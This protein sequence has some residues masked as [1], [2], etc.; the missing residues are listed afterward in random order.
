MPKPLTVLALAAFVAVDVALVAGVYS[1]VNQDPPTTSA[2]SEATEQPRTSDQIAFDFDPTDAGV[3]DVANDGTFVFA[4]RGDCE[5]KG[6]KL[7]VSEEY[8]ADPEPSKVGLTSIQA[9][10]ASTDGRLTVAGSDQDCNPLQRSS[11]DGGDNWVTDP[12]VTLWTIDPGDPKTIVSP[13]EGDS[14]PGCTVSSLS[15]VDDDFARVTC[16]DGLVKGTGN[17]GKEW[18]DLGRLDNVRTATF[19]TYDSGFA[20][21][22][23]Q[24]CAAHVFVTSDSGRSWTPTSCIVGD[25]ARAIAS[26]DTTLV[27][28]VGEKPQVFTSV[29][30]GADFSQP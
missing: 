17:G 2:S 13:S 7:W 22:R 19:R 6:S 20:L 5:D 30:N 10:K 8:G 23:Y 14:E 21:A 25:P 12:E 11:D 4:V 15:Q 18:L 1:H 16:I 27:A 24:G 3:L 26:S 29:D 9:V 28:V